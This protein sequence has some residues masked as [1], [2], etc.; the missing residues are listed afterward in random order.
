M[1]QNTRHPVFQLIMWMGRKGDISL[2]TAI[3]R[4]VALDLDGLDRQ[5]IETILFARGLPASHSEL[6]NQHQELISEET[7]AFGG[8]DTTK[9]S[10]NPDDMNS[11]IRHGN[12]KSAELVKQFFGQSD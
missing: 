3:Q 12:G 10:G 8:Y 7:N 5:Q 9:G 11:V 1:A 6:Y 4:I 2:E